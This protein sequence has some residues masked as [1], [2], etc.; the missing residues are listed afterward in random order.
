MPAIVMLSQVI[1]YPLL[2]SLAAQRIRK[3]E[4]DLD[5]SQV[6]LEQ[7]G[8]LRA[9]ILDS[10]LEISLQPS[11]NKLEKALTHS[12]SLYLMADLLGLVQYDPGTSQA[13]LINTYDL[14]REDHIEKVELAIDQMPELFGKLVQHETIVSNLDSELISEKNYLMQTSGYNQIG[15]MLLYPLDETPNQFKWAILGLSPYTNRQWGLE[16]IQR[17]DCLRD[18]L[19][20][21]LEKASRLEL[22]ARQIGD[23]QTE[24][25]Q[26]ETTLSHLSAIY[27]ESQAELQGLSKDL[28][29]TQANWTEEVNLWIQRQ[30][31]LETELDKLQ[32]TIEENQERIAE[33]DALR[34]QKEQL[35]ETILRNSE[36][37]A[38]IKTAIDQASLLL[39]KLTNQDE[40]SGQAEESTG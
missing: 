11:Q 36:Q 26:K 24:L 20:K 7:N 40:P 32:K 4:P 21:V 38:Q 8:Q 9:N 1:Y 33:V 3:P 10:F 30:K 29:Q 15:N 28:F 23:L 22:E 16:D 19:I 35:E 12:L 18:N 25:L 5:L 27:A 34:Y 37:S 39:Q 13:A 31:E 17:L 6:N 2:V 14:I